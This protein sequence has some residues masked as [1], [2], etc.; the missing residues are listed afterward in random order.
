MKLCNYS[1]IAWF[2]FCVTAAPIS[3]SCLFAEEIVPRAVTAEAYDAIE[4]LAISP[5]SRQLIVGNM[6][7]WIEVLKLPLGEKLRKFRGPKFIG[8]LA[9][10]P[11]GDILAGYCVDRPDVFLYNTKDWT[12]LRPI[13]IGDMRIFQIA[14]SSDGKTFMVLGNRLIPGDI[15][16]A[17]GPCVVRAWD[18][19]RRTRMYE[20]GGEQA[21]CRNMAISADGAT[22]ATTSFGGPRECVIEYWKAQTGTRIGSKIATGQDDIRRLVFLPRGRLASVG[23]ETPKEIT[24][25]NVTI[26]IWDTSKGRLLQTLKA[27]TGTVDTLVPFSGDKLISASMNGTICLWDLGSSRE[28]GKVDTRSSVTR[29]SVSPNGQFLVCSMDLADLR[30]WRLSDAFPVLVH[31]TGASEQRTPTTTPAA[32]RR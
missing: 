31:G 6:N 9:L 13:R 4:G 23:I 27:H 30:I 12:P 26:K 16:N 15:L 17:D 28:I 18:L 32:G 29:L 21:S 11:N 14:F 25:D 2:L 7:G 5:D 24:S 8:G 22:L 10:S 1:T 20:I 19:A 3:Q